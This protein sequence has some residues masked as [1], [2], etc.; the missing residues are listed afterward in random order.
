MT[1]T[2]VLP[3]LIV[4]LPLL[5][6]RLLFLSIVTLK[7]LSI[8]ATP[9]EVNELL[10]RR[11]QDGAPPVASSV[12]VSVRSLLLLT[13]KFCSP[14]VLLDWTAG[15][16]TEK[17]K[18]PPICTTCICFVCCRSFSSVHI[19]LNFATRSLSLGL[20]ESTDKVNGFSLAAVASS[21]VALAGVILSQ[22]SCP[23]VEE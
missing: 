13:V 9:E 8:A 6:F 22:F 23:A 4:I 17:M 20:S 5:G 19:T 21:C 1:V 15:V 12:A 16:L 10:S 2:S 14:P 3:F 11:N 18:S 7:A